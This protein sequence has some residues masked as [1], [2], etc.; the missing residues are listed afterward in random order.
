[1][2][3]DVAAFGDEPGAAIFVSVFFIKI[4]F[5]AVG[6][7]QDVAAYGLND[8]FHELRSVGFYAFPFLCRTDSFVGDGFAAILVFS[9]TWLHVRKQ[10][11]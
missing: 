7:E 1:M 3:N 4:G 5:V 8:I 11:A 6:A 10:S 9:D 2:T